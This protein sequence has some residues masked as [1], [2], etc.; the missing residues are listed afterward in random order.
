MRAGWAHTLQRLRALARPARLQIAAA[1][2]LALALLSPRWPL[3]QP[4][5][6]HVVYLDI[7]QSM[8][9]RD[10][11]LGEGPG[12]GQPASRLAFVQ[13]AL[14]EAL[15]ALP[16]GSRLGLGLF[17][18]YRVLLLTTPVE[19]CANYDDLL[20]VVLRIDGRMS[21]AGASEVSKGV[22]WS[23]R[24][25]R[26]L[27]DSPTVMF[28]TDGHEAPPLRPGS[29]PH[30][31][32][33]LGQVQGTLLGVGGA[34]LSPIPKF[35]PEG[36]LLGVWEPDEVLQTDTF[37]AGRTLGGNRQSLVESDGRPVQAFRGSGTE[38][39]SSLKEPHLLVLAGQVGLQYRR[40]ATPRDLVDALRDERLARR[41]VV[42]RD[43]RF[44][45]AAVALLL[46]VVAAF[47]PRRHVSK[48]RVG[49]PA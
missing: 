38:H 21:W 15:L 16:C 26:Q 45:P 29:E 2:L 42:A 4:H 30:F 34:A 28:I 11:T 6:N 43:L 5:W 10:M 46:L 49:A 19:V 39:L 22:F 36:H 12:A 41:V 7:T 32:E 47:S 9:T 23:I 25:T 31:N 17:T 35:D 18:E 13:Q 48:G 1:L 40:L 44:V 27:D 24:T 33:P 14:H 3:A 8:N 20:A 37:S